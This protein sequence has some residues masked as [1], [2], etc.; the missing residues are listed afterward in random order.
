MLVCARR[1]IRK[2]GKLVSSYVQTYVDIAGLR[3]SSN[4]CAETGPAS[5]TLVANPGPLVADFHYWQR[6]EYEVFILHIGQEDRFTFLGNPDIKLRAEFVD[7]RDGSSTLH[8]RVVMSFNPDPRRLLHIPQG[9]AMFFSGL[10][11]VTVRSE[12][13]LFAPS[14]KTHYSVGNDQIRIST[15][16]AIQDFPV[17][18]VNDLPLPPDVLQIICKR[19]QEMLR[20]GA[21]YETSFGIYADDFMYRFARSRGN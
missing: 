19:E 8:G 6:H 21:S 4:F 13:V 10:T 18:G 3:W 16:T 12:P 17:V 20:T 15:G 7:C 2:A 1:H 9:I 11:A 5:Y 14:K